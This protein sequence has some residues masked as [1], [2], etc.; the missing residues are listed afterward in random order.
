MNC[1]DVDRL[2]S[3]GIELR[4]LQVR[5]GP[6]IRNCPRCRPLVEFMAEPIEAP[7]D[8]NDSSRKIAARLT[9]KLAPAKPL[10]STGQIA[11]AIVASAA[12]SFGLWTAIMGIPGFNRLD[13]MRRLA[14][15]V[16]SFVLLVLL[17]ISMARLLLPAAPRPISPTILLLSVAVG[18][19]ALASLLFPVQPVRESFCRRFR[20]SAVRLDYL[21]LCQFSDLGARSPRLRH[22]PNAL[23][24]NYWSSRRHCGDH[25]PAVDLSRSRGCA[26]RLLARAHRPAQHRWRCAGRV[27]QARRCRPVLSTAGVPGFI[28]SYQSASNSPLANST[29]EG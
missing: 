9:S 19:P 27:H 21:V 11:V 29:D 28:T 18:Y 20:V 2:L 14:L 17:S 7:H 4:E 12:V 1:S 26:H 25:D 13:H 8:E 10:A 3:E 22:S 5:A 24:S 16:Y 23:R 6:H 15:T